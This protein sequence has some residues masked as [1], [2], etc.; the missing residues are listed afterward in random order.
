M[1]NSCLSAPAERTFNNRQATGIDLRREFRS[2][3]LR[4][5]RIGFVADHPVKTE[6]VSQSHFRTLSLMRS[7]VQEHEPHSFIVGMSEHLA[8]RS[9]VL[10]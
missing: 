6:E 4:A 5:S 8:F 1:Q 2:D 7:Y 10:D 9:C 3:H